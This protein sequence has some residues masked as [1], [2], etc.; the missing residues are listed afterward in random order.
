MKK[1]FLTLQNYDRATLES[2]LKRAYQ[3]KL[4]PQSVSAVAQGK[5]LALLFEKEST[6]TRV[7]FEVAMLKLGGQAIYLG[8]NMSQISRGETYADTARVLSR[9]VDAIVL[10]TFSQKSIQDLAQFA[11]VPV[12]NGLT[13]LCHPCQLMADMLTILEHKSCLDQKV[14]YL[15][16]GNN[17]AYSWVEA[18]KIFGFEL[19]C[20][21][22]EDYRIQKIQDLS[23]YP[24]ITLLSDPDSAINGA[25]VINTDTWFSMGQEVS[26]KKRKAFEAFQINTNLLKKADPSAIVMHCLPAH[27]GE[28]I[29]DEVLDGPQSVVFD[30]AENRLYAQM[31]LLEFL[32]K[33][34]SK[35]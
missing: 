6:R 14:A 23:F 32:L 22:P 30:Q 8:Q 31:A 20:A 1:D 34:G 25:T 9:Y 11:T 18:A 19:R 3:M 15:G 26:N 5:V 21:M 29:T 35:N 28:E 7:S 17:M 33:D 16:D 10:R 27:R 4:E 24:N 13:D 2:I 12:I